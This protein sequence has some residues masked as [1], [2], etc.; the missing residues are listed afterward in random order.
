VV[1]G[2]RIAAV[3]WEMAAIGPG[4]IDLAALIAGWDENSQRRMI[5]AFGPVQPA[6]L[7]AVCGSPGRNLYPAQLV[8]GCNATLGGRHIS[9][10]VVS[11]YI[12]QSAVLFARHACIRNP[13]PET[14]P[15]VST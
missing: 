14:L 6:D 1:T 13:R 10:P 5:A 2:G 3:D 7:G 15:T 8:K 9:K 4:V 12:A 11:P